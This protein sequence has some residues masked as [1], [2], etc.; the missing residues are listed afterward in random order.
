MSAADRACT[1]MVDALRASGRVR[2]AV[3]D[4]A[5]RAVPRHLFLPGATVAAAYADGAVAVQHV[6]GVAT[7]SASQ[8]SMVAIMLE[9]LELRPGHRVLEIGAGTG[10]NAALMARIVGPTGHVTTVDIDPDLVAGTT[11]HL[12]AAGV[13]G[14]EVVCGDGALGHPAGAPYD[15]VVLTVGSGDVWPAWVAQLAPAGRLLLPLALRGSQLSIALDLAPDGTL[16]SHSQRTCGFIRLRGMG[17]SARPAVALS[18]GLA[19]RGTED[20]PVPD[21][22]GVVAALTEPGELVASPVV[23]GPADTWDGFGFWLALTDPGALR[24]VADGPDSGLPDP[25]GPA[26]VVACAAEPGEVPGLAVVVAG[27]GPAA[28]RAYGPGGP[29]QAE[30]MLAALGAWA[31]AGAPAAPEWRFTVVP[32]PPPLGPPPPGVCAVRMA[33][34]H[35]LA[36][37]P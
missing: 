25:V 11:R 20:G 17:A 26:G 9:Q 8:P 1:A 6:D 13:S 24:L 12:A 18:G 19:L 27:A 34:C 21:P 3:V 14:V 22:A 15:R 32:G 30:R 5:L 33:H 10:W 23:V 7:S 4:A 2:S 29:A 36:E 31:A 35:L 37:L 16:H 28:V